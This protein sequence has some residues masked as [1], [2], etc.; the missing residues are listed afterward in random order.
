MP[1]YYFYLLDSEEVVDSDGTELPDLDAAR[2]HAR[3]VARELTF[4]RDGMLQRSWSQWTMSVR[5]TDGQVL[6]SFPLG[7]FESRPTGNPESD[8][9]RQ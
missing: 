3:Q 6:L 1:K 8:N 4:K 9:P 5:D 7:D 2:E